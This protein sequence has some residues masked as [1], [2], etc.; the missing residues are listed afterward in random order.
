M[1]DQKDVTAKAVG[2]AV[3]LGSTWLAQQVIQRL[4]RAA[5]GHNPPDATNEGDH[6]F[7]EVAAA[8]AVTGAVVALSRVIATRGMAKV[9]K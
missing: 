9:L 3:A 6:R 2:L 4:W 8:A 7:G 1:P 5:F